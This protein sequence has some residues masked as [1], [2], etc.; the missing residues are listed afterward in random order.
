MDYYVAKDQPIRY[1]N[2]YTDYE[3]DPLYDQIW[4]YEYDPSVFYNKDA[5]TGVQSFTSKTPVTQFSDAGA[6]SMRLK[7]RDNPVGTN[8]ALDEYRLWSDESVYQK[9]LMVHNR[10]VA[11]MD[12]TVSADS[13]NAQMCV[14]NVTDS[15][16]D[17]D[18]QNE[19]GKG[20]V[21]KEYKWKKLSD[22]AWTEG[23]IPNKLAIGGIYLIS[24][25]AVDQEGWASAPCIQIINTDDYIVREPE[26]DTELPIIHLELEKTK[27]SAGE[28]VQITGYATDN[29]GVDVFELYI[30]DE[31]VL[32]HAG[33]VFYTGT[34]NETVK[35]TAKAVDIYGNV[36]YENQE[37]VIV[38]TSDRT[39]PT[40][41]ITSPENGSVMDFSVQIKGSAYD[42]TLLNN[43]RLEYKK[44]GTD[45]Y[46]LIN[47]GNTA[48]T[49]GVLGEWNVSGLESGS[50]DVRLSAAD[51]AGN[52]AYVIYHYE[53]K[54]SE[55]GGIIDSG[56]V[57]R[58]APVIVFDLSKDIANVGEEV[59]ASISVTDDTGI[60]SVQVYLDDALV[61][62]SAGEIT[63]SKATPCTSKIKVYAT[64]KNGNTAVKEL[65][66]I[67]IDD[68]DKIAPTAAISTPAHAARVSGSVNITGTA[69]DDTEMLRY[70]LAYKA[71]DADTFTAI[72]EGYNAVADGVLGIWD[73]TALK[74]GV[75]D[76]RLTVEDK[77]GNSSYV[78]YSYL[79][80]NNGSAEE[81]D[82]IA[83]EIQI[84]LSK[85]QADVGETVSCKVTATDNKKLEA[86]KVYLN[87]AVILDGQG[88][89]T[90]NKAEASIVKIKVYAVD[91]AGNLSVKTAECLVTDNR[92]KT[93]PT[94]E[95]TAPA[96]A[97][98]I[99]GSV[100]IIGTAK[101]DTALLRYV[102]QYRLQGTEEFT[103]LKE[104]TSAVEN[105][106]L[107][108]LPTAYLLNGV[109]EVR[110]TA[111]DKSGNTALTQF[112]YIVNNDDEGSGVIPGD[113]NSD[114]D[115]VNPSL[116][117]TLSKNAAS[118]NEKVKVYVSASDNKELATLT[119]TVNGEEIAI[120][121][122]KGEFTSDTPGE[123]IVKALAVDASGNETEKSIGCS[124]YDLSDNTSPKLE[125]TSPE[126]GASISKPA[127]IVGS[128]YDETKLAYYTVEY[129]AK[130][131]ASYTLLKKDINEK[132]NEALAQFDTTVLANGIYE[133][134]IK[135]VDNGGNSTIYTGTYS[136][137]GQL[138][139]GNM[140]LGFEDVS[141]KLSGVNV[142]VTRY[143]SSAN[144]LS[145]DFG[146]GWSLGMGGITVSAM[147]DMANGW[148]MQS[149]GEKLAIGYYLTED[150]SH[151]IVVNYGDG[152]SERFK[153]VLTPERQKYV[154]IMT[155]KITF[156][157]NDPESSNTL[158]LYGD[159]SFGT[160]GYL[161]STTLY[162]KSMD[163][164]SAVKFKLTLKDKTV[165]V[166][167]MKNGAESIT[168]LA[169]N[170]IKVTSNGY[171]DASGKGVV[172][173][174]DSA[175]RITAI[176]EPDGSVTKY[177]Y[178]AQDNLVKVTN[179]A[180]NT[181][182]FIYDNNHNIIS[183]IDARG[184]EAARN[185]YDEN[186]RLV[187][188]VDSDGNRMKFDYDVEGRSQV[189]TDKLGKKTIYV[190][191]DR[192]NIL[193]CTDANGNT[194]TNTYDSYGH[195]LTGTDALGN[196]TKYE[197]SASGNLVS[198]TNALGNKVQNKYNSN[199]QLVS[200]TA[201]GVTQMLVNYDES[202]LLK[203]TED[204]LG[205]ITD[206]TYD[207]KYRI[208]GISDEIGSVQKFTYDSKG[209]VLT[210]VNGAG[211]TASFTY[212]SDGKC[213]SKTIVRTTSAGTENLTE[214]YEYDKL[215]QLVKVIYADGSVTSVAYDEIGQMTAATDSAGRRTLYDYD[216][217]GNLIK[218][219][220]CD[221]TTETFTY[222]AM[223]RN[224]G[225]TDRMGRTVKMT[226]D[227]VGNLLTKT[228]PNGASETYT[229]DA[230]Y[231]LVSVT[232][233]NGGVTSYE[234]DA[235]DRNTAI[236]DALG[237][238]TEFTYNENAMLSGMKDAKGNVFQYEYDANG[239]RTKI[240]MPDG[241]STSSEYDARGR[242]TKQI[243]Q[244]G[245]ATS[246]TYD[247]ADRLI[248]VTD[249]V[250]ST[251]NYTYSA[252]GELVAVTDANGNV[253]SYEYDNMGRVVKTTNAAGKSASLTYD[254]SGSVLTSTD[255]AGVTISYT[256]DEYGR[257]TKE[258]TG[259]ETIAYTY[260]IDG[261]LLT[262]T[263]K[264]GVIAYTY[265][266]MGAL[267]GVKTADGTKISYSYDDAG[268]LSKVTTPFGGTSYSYDLTDRLVRVVDRNGYATQYEYDANGNRTAVRYANG[269]TTTYKYDDLNR[270][271]DEES[272]D[273]DGHLV[274]KYAYTLG[275]AG[276]RLAA[277]ESDRTVAYGYD[278]L[279]RLVS[280]KVT[281][282]GATSETT[283]TYDK[284]GNRLTKTENGT[285]TKYSYNN[286]N[287]LVSETGITYAYDDNGNLVKKTESGK[288][289]SYTYDNHNR[290]IRATVQSG[291]DVS[292]EEYAYDYAGNRTAKVT[293][294]E[295]VKYLVDTNGALAQV[296][297]ELDGSGN[298]KTYY[299]RG[300]ELL[301]LERTDET[302]WYLYDGHGSV[303][304]LVDE[305]GA[306]TDT[307]TYDAFGNLT[308]STGDT[309]NSYLYCGEQYDAN[310]GFYYLRA[311]YMNPSTGTFISMDTYQG[312]MFDPVSLHKYLYA[313]AN[314]VMYCDPTGHMTL[315]ETQ[316]CSALAGILMTSI[317]LQNFNHITAAFSLALM[318]VNDWIS[319]YAEADY[320]TTVTNENVSEQ[321]KDHVI[322]DILDDTIAYVKD[323][324]KE[325][326]TDIEIALSKAKLNKPS[327]GYYVYLRLDAS[328]K[329]EYVGITNDIVRRKGE[330]GKDL[331]SLNK[332]PMKR[333]QA[334]GVEQYIIEKNPQFTN[335]INSISKYNILYPVAI[336]FGRIFT[337][338]NS[339]YLSYRE[340]GWVN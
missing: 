147:A 324:T 328:G 213:T 319:N 41:E 184:I 59:K 210:S 106:V 23:P 313:N 64:D 214:H 13:A 130:G 55:D 310:T 71:Q 73:T 113:D 17:P 46:A 108:T 335:K 241:S 81:K 187:A 339:R 4:E 303:R 38:D 93:M 165:V 217:N 138:K 143:Y 224:T 316:I 72:A 192:G 63:F 80:N 337:N 180:G 175:G 209:N 164:F 261:K 78:Q 226:Y 317:I 156:K 152:T 119:V 21:S 101:D 247:G 331:V 14:V 151:D 157:S 222:D 75:Y 53:L 288:T 225:A 253:T 26:S 168:D 314:P 235:I 94:A 120:T 32:D 125:I 332:T 215:G 98:Q 204:A 51:G 6:Y 155:G 166:V 181:V 102:L 305:T 174:R 306:V 242:I 149:T 260:N 142:N 272:V 190:Y 177:A 201:M 20:I 83:P 28:R 65:S 197:I 338:S 95:I 239:N 140:N 271:I 135:A 182:Q 18:H 35:I 245:S 126:N 54:A 110:L 252:V 329:P 49:D 88:S 7:V 193:K 58:T 1:I 121:N 167:S 179:P 308:A 322:D 301:S 44:D 112:A 77:S 163:E 178:D 299:T 336:R 231:R 298:L 153:V 196:M 285:E 150:Y 183:I 227:N 327:V 320:V 191:D 284:V 254:Q 116:T 90:F 267:S 173:T 176:T 57:D 340:K 248:S 170:V 76:V 99:S 70:R 36:A 9:V 37:L 25:T 11:E 312:S 109:Y 115:I 56:T 283:Y 61:M 33:R 218:T 194:T 309:E 230:K 24:L 237:N 264:N 233:I 104:S 50:Y 206:Y 158:E 330:H 171:Y 282:N 134:R 311:R 325:I 321:F 334:R 293:E 240:I 91:A 292:I 244:N 162:D 251:W 259:G 199:N 22:T 133:I 255:Y 146:T 250:G 40:V 205:N 12:V 145:G 87:D 315:A 290:L 302:R 185:E 111:T 208:T 105:G 268:R 84:V 294:G 246:Y 263:D 189:V 279:Y 159:N 27:A 169:G 60:D 276:E 154:P 277:E 202:G 45:T 198:V 114:K 74:N 19:E 333:N 39:P 221:N 137:E 47:E 326:A 257:I 291:Q 122:G 270:L 307:Y 5:K 287:Q 266:D 273:K 195:Q 8:D 212:D 66:C 216:A 89:F 297:C 79:V 269:I 62:E 82:E 203:K 29:M 234:Y 243:D 238:R 200:V 236:V 144:K 30:N 86:V 31:L 211:E 42:E 289:T 232:G 48:V 275:K 132:H 304:A 280:E 97:S 103:T 223:G 118:I 131:A 228:Y 219:T 186:G 107:G 318:V 96:H 69:S 281:E 295:T 262:V 3:N 123:V 160:L 10:P 265:D 286:L 100:D 161:G 128:V 92:D 278:K 207:G 300:S 141:T 172:F 43:Y 124:F 258:E 323:F 68:S 127:D 67:F 148:T 274:V 188:T 85:T 2:A 139:V 136:V 16:Y 249:A 220:Y 129:R 34:Q 117:L 256:Y 15:C 296:L 229:Y 52:T